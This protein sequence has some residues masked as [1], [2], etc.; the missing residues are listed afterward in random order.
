[1]S[2]TKISNV[3]DFRPSDSRPSKK[4]KLIS[5]LHYQI[6]FT[7]GRYAESFWTVACKSMVNICIHIHYDESKDNFKLVLEAHDNPTT[8]AIKSVFECII[9]EGVDTNG[10]KL[11]RKDLHN[12]YFMV[13]ATKLMKIF[14]VT[15]IKDTPLNLTKYHDVDGIKF[16][17]DGNENDMSTSFL[18]PFINT[19][20]DNI[21]ANLKEDGLKIEIS[22]NVL[23]KMANVS[24]DVNSD[25]IIIEL[26]TDK[27]E[28][29]KLVVSFDGELKGQYSFLLVD[30]DVIPTKDDTT[31]WKQISYQKYL[32]RKFNKFINSLKCAR[33]DIMLPNEGRTTMIISAECEGSTSHTIF[34]ASERIDSSD[35]E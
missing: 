15:Q 32:S 14:G 20:P 17:S 34:I 35:S 27:K 7:N 5:K 4:I 21:I 6:V 12:E 24:K 31:E 26:L 29:R 10:N 3:D 30:G 25:L 9:K 28:N 11:K 33:C 22:T 13:D 23:Q 18:L 8:M 19:A 1:M 16:E 2:Y